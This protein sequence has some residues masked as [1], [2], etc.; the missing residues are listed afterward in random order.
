MNINS[1]P[2]VWFWQIP[3]YY[4]CHRLSSDSQSGA[5][6]DFKLEANAPIILQCEQEQMVSQLNHKMFSLS[7][8]D[9]IGSRRTR[10]TS[11]V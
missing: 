1:V 6:D 9:R 3:M 10:S 2:F 5:K 7:I 8:G 11:S 4:I